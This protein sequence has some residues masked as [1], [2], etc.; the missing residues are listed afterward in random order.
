MHISYGRVRGSGYNAPTGNNMP[1]HTAQGAQKGITA[2]KKEEEK[3]GRY[4]VLP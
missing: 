1:T 4:T 3:S 2:E